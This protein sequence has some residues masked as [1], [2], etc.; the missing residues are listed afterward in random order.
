MF[1]DIKDRAFFDE[2]KKIAEGFKE[3]SGN[4]STDLNNTMFKFHTNHDM[5]P[6]FQS[7]NPTDF[8]T[9]MDIGENVE[10]LPDMQDYRMLNAH[11]RN[12]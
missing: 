7:P 1:K 10:S 4:P 8:Q 2:L 3:I 5:Q 11:L 6:S 12:R 9:D